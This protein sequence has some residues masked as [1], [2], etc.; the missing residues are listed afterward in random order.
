MS[1]RVCVI[2]LDAAEATLIERWAAEGQL[3]TLGRLTRAGVAVRLANCLETLP[4]AIWPELTTGR[5]GGRLGRF[6]HSRK[7]HTGDACFRPI[8][9]DEVDPSQYYWS[10]ASAAGRRVAIMDQP[11][12]AL[13]RGLNGIQLLGWGSHDRPFPA[14]AEPGPLLP[15]IESRFGVHPVA[16]CDARDKTIEGYRSLLHDLLDGVERRTAV[17]LDIMGR[18]SWDLVACAFTEAHCVGHQFWTF[19]DAGPP[20]R[21]APP[22]LR[23]A[24]LRVYAR[25]D[26]AIARIIDAAGAGAT[27]LVVA[28]HGMGPKI[29]G[30][31]LL[32][33]FLVRLGLG[34]GHGLAR[35]V[36]SWVPRRFRQLVRRTAPAGALRGL[37]AAAGSLPTPLESPRT[38]AIAVPNNRCG[39]IRLNLRGREPHGCVDRGGEA[40]AILA[41][42][43]RELLALEH[44]AS[45]ERI[46]KRVMTA[47]E[48]FGS[49]HHPDLPDL[50]VV[51]RTDLGP[52]EAC[53]SDWVGVI[54]EPFWGGRTGDHTP[55]SR[56]WA[57][58]PARPSGV[59]LPAPNV[60]DLAPTVLRLLDVA[61]PAA[62]EGRA[63]LVPSTAPVRT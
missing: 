35:Q 61:P 27:V 4:G 17:V 2:C 55:E 32:P 3:P 41:E 51:F 25:I 36:R 16:S 24:I 34:S 50:I 5:S 8:G 48:A 49:D 7:L 22:D 12:A 47:A 44:L 26:G 18:E 15:E 46:V 14:Q 1:A 57:L 43:R 53:R 11:Q 20:R 62:L 9:L 63:L 13:C 40:D 54:R 21:A 28:S 6:Y 37:Q 39:A 58:G 42:M 56:L 60:L 29:G 30:P 52:L 59:D 19:F 10:V 33:E 31:Q 23:E 38:R 45:G